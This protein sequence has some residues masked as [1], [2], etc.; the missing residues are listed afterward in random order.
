MGGGSCPDILETRLS[1]VCICNGFPDSR[2]ITFELYRGWILQ[3]TKNIGN[4]NSIENK[5]RLMQGSLTPE[6]SI[7][8]RV[9]LHA[10]LILIGIKFGRYKGNIQ[11]DIES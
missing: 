3:N 6:R 11:I 5:S 4:D 10:Y 2:V 7:Y 1:F 9:P 8:H